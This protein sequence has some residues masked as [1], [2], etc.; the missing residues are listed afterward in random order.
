MIDTVCMIIR[1]NVSKN[2]NE[3]EM[4]EYIRNSIEKSGRFED[5][6]RM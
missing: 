4:T 3:N 2:N 1:S 5:L 6:Y